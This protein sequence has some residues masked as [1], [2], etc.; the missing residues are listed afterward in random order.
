MGLPILRDW[1]SVEKVLRE[2][3]M[4]ETGSED[5]A[6]LVLRLH[7]GESGKNAEVLPGVRQTAVLTL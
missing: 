1:G 4:P 7:P 5:S 3:W 6:L 2:L